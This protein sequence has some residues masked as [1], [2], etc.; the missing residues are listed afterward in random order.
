MS[1][2]DKINLLDIGGKLGISPPIS[3]LDDK[4]EAHSG[5]STK[6]KS[7]NSNKRRSN[8]KKRIPI[9][10]LNVR[11]DATLRDEFRKIVADRKCTDR[12]VLEEAIKWLVRKY[13]RNASKI[14]ET[15]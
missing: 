10:Q 1:V 3:T 6:S 7:Q 13:Q 14:H 2:N 8:K 4:A 5:V 15:K 11:I 12:I 9:H